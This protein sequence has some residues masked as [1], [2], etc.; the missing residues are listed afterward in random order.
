VK[1]MVCVCVC[2]GEPSVKR[3][4]VHERYDEFVFNQPSDSLLQRI[5]MCNSRLVREDLVHTGSLS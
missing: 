1:L 2:T 5:Q 4:V 3:P